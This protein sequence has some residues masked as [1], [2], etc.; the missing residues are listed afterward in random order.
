MATLNSGLGGTA[1]YG[2]NAFTDPANTIIGNT[3]DGSVEVDITSVFPGGINFYGTTY[4]SI[5]INSNGNISF[6]SANTSYE[7]SDLSSS[8][9]AVIAPFWADVDLNKGGEIYW[10]LDP[11][12][13]KVTITWLDV[14]P[15]SVGSTDRNSFQL[16]LT[17][18]GGTDFNA[19]F[20][21][22]DIQWTDGGGAP[23]QAG[24][25]DGGSNTTLLPGSGDPAALATYETTDFGYHDTAGTVDLNFVNGT[26][27][28]PD[29]IVEGT[30][31]ADTIDAT[32]TGDP[33]FDRVDA[34]D[35]SGPNHNEDTIYGYDGDDTISAGDGNDLVYGG[36]GNDTIDGG[37]G[38]D[39]LYGDGGPSLTPS[40]PAT[41]DWST[42]T[43]NGTFAIAGSTTST[44]VTI[45]TTTNTAGQT[46]TSTTDGS[47]SA[48]G[49]WA[50]AVTEPVVSTLS[51]AN[52]VENLTFEI[53]DIDYR[54]GQWDDRITITAT[55]ADGNLVTVNYSN[56]D[57]HTVTGNT[58]DASG[59]GSFGIDTSGALD[60]VT[61][62][63]PGPLSNVTITFD[64]GESYFE[65][66]TFGVGNM[67]FDI[68][69]PPP[70]GG[71]DVIDGGAGADV[72][73]GQDGNDTLT[74]GLGA[75]T[76][77]GGAGTD[78]LNIGAGD[79][80]TGGL[81][82]DSFVLSAAGLD[83]SGGTITVD[84]G[85]DPDGSDVDTLNL[86]GL[87][88]SASDIVFDASNPE[89]GTATL[90]DG[91]VVTF[92]NI[93]DVIICFTH[94]TLIQTDRGA[95]PIEDL[96]CGDRVVTRDNGLQ[97][98]RWMGQK[99]V[100]G[101]GK[102]APIR[103]GKGLLGNDAPLFVSPQHRM[104]YAGTEASLMFAQ[105][106]VMVPAKHLVDGRNVV[107]TPQDQV[108]YYHMLFDRHEVVFANGAA[109]ESFHPG[110][111]G[112][113]AIDAAAREELFDLFP[114][115][116]S[117]PAQYGD[118]ARMVL[119]RYEAQALRLT[120]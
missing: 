45:T 9:A 7:I 101:H 89:N 20:I 37:D 25:H 117:D 81:G 39:T 105:P 14:A 97:K 72:I 100:K 29:G 17:S 22:G 48:P 55:D 88:N 83:G 50:T 75:D 53:Y 68:M 42:V 30:A 92:S 67:N 90:S 120:L 11:S 64:N 114:T 28:F 77:D 36:A 93:E 115:L 71:D 80:A 10:D 76:L 43:E 73:Y 54:S 87:V 60:T 12:T 41:L 110:H 2:E 84:G 31:G 58:V 4:T 74:G 1:G 61:V 6:G 59:A 5:F 38:N 47:P 99:T 107:I 63:I 23:A 113:G 51:F 106:E 15:Y 57:H 119:R 8:A 62:T 79:T 86:G 24:I 49:L 108:T 70:T 111:E 56:L 109:S 96:R 103:I 65:S 112:L 69:A 35:W 16:V 44:S 13:G 40:D 66:G 78:T 52:P 32:Y 46:A 3:D 118:T 102:L 85:E 34:G 19:E 21:Y 94:G 82:S 104:V 91:T 26:P 33:E 98:I 116:R 27:H 18:N 95:R